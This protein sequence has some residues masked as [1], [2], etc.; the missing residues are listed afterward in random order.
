MGQW[1]F[2]D[3]EGLNKNFY[4][5]FWEVE[6]ALGELWC[7]GNYCMMYHILKFAWGAHC[8][9]P[10]SA[11]TQTECIHPAPGLVDP[12]LPVCVPAPGTCCWDSGL[13]YLSLQAA[14]AP[15]LV[16]WYW[17]QAGRYG[18]PGHKRLV[19]PISWSQAIGSIQHP[20]SSLSSNGQVQMAAN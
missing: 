4:Q 20:W 1:N 8:L 16:Q 6:R 17:D 19:M 3:W 10:W 13:W 9:L 11:Q 7:R 18:A 14:R 5:R 12:T 15:S 2:I